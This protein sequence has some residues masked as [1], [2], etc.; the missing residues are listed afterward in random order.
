M[1]IKI[2][3][4]K[5][6]KTS[7]NFASFKKSRTFAPFKLL[8]DLYPANTYTNNISVKVSYSRN[9]IHLLRQQQFEQHPLTDFLF[10]YTMKTENATPTT[11][12]TQYC[13]PAG[14]LQEYFTDRVSLQDFARTMRSLMFATSLNFMQQCQDGSGYVPTEICRGIDTLNNFVEV[15]TPY[16]SNPKNK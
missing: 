1:I 6:Q 13:F 5:K 10:L 4:E 3:T 11:P 7:K 14:A 16:L 12:T 2:I 9:A 15:L 8:L